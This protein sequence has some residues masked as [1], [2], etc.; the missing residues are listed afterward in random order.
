VYFPACPARVFA[1]GLPE[2]VLAVSSR[3]GFP[4]HVPPEA[5]G[6]CCGM[7]FS[8]KGYRR[9][10]RSLVN[11]AI[12]SLWEWSGEG[13]IPVVVDTSSC[14]YTLRTC[15]A[16]LTPGNRERHDRLTILDGI[17]LAH[18]HLLES[19]VARRKK[20]SVAIHPV[21]SSVKLDTAR[22]LAAVARSFADEVTVPVDAG[23]CGFAGDRGFTHPELTESATRA[24][25][26]EVLGADHDGW[27]SSNTTCE[28]AMTRATGHAYESFWRL[29][30]ET[31]R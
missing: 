18:D 7:P 11:R 6:V 2:S 19:L 13:A 29:L 15:R 8:S 31:T 1:S 20:R 12:A 30:D 14:A 9:S 3:A 25:A 23:C 28:I 24:E 27:Y 4:L 22:K 16:D 17:E 10:S 21:C 5:A 26:A